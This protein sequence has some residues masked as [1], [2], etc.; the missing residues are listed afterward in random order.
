MIV[1]IDHVADWMLIYQRKQTLFE[2][3]DKGDSTRTNY[4]SQVGEQVLISNYQ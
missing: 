2:K 1:P 4:H 3:N